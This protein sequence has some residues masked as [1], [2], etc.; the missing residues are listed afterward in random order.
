MIMKRTAIL[1]AL[2]LML[3]AAA[4]AQGRPQDPVG[5]VVYSLPQTS[6]VFDVEVL[7]EDFHAGPYASYAK[8]YLGIDVRLSD[9]V[10]CSLSKVVMTPFVEADH[11]NRYV[12]NVQNPT[13]ASFLKLS[14]MGLISFA[15]ANYSKDAF[16][17]FP[18]PG[19]GDFN[20]KGVTSNLSTESTTLSA[21]NSVSVQQTMVVEKSEEKRAAEAAEMIFSLRKK[22]VQIITG[23]TDMTYAGE[24]MGAA[25]D[26]MTR[27]EKEYMTLFTGYS[28]TETQSV[29]FEVVPEAGREMQRYIAFKF[30]ETGGITAADDPMGGAPVV[31]ELTVEELAAGAVADEPAAKPSKGPFLFYR[32]PA[33]CKAKLIKGADVILQSRIPVYQL[34]VQSSIP[35]SMKVK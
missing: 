21:Y 20:D 17:R 32:T 18:A 34:G 12:L 3:G 25:I 8:K 27:L 29:R 19:K 31:L 7:R 23:D 16:W 22:R 24:A 4:S 14:S 1:S 11:S 30:S 10:N 6:L 26:E 9:E 5:T 13:D 35:V 28:D 33:V 2:L 15:D